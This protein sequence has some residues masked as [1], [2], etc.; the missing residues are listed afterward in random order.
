M[1]EDTAGLSPQ[2]FLLIVCLVIALIGLLL[3]Y[4]WLQRRRHEDESKHLVVD[5]AEP[6]SLDDL[7]R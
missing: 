5:M 1:I 2:A 4:R 7:K 6:E 3:G